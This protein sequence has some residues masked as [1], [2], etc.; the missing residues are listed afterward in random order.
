MPMVIIQTNKI[1]QERLPLFGGKERTIQQGRNYLTIILLFQQYTRK[2][3]IALLPQEQGLGDSLTRPT[4]A[5]HGGI[6]GG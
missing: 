1:K 6:G 4:S 2:N 5:Q 3:P